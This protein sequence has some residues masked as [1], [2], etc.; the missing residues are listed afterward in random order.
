MPRQLNSKH[1]RP[2]LVLA[3]EVSESEFAT[4]MAMIDD[5]RITTRAADGQQVGIRGE[6]PGRNRH[7]ECV[8][9]YAE[10]IVEVGI[11]VANIGEE[12]PGALDVLKIEGEVSSGDRLPNRK[13]Q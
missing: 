1:A 10:L 2:R 12:D 5:A 7:R 11:G 9:A 4:I 8:D 6:K 13:R 3:F